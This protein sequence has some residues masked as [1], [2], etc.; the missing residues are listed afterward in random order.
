MTSDSYKITLYIHYMTYFLV[1]RCL[2]HFHMQTPKK[3]CVISCNFFKIDFYKIY[4]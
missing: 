4:Y 3:Y 1:I 2:Y